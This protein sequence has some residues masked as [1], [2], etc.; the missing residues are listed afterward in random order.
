MLRLVTTGTTKPFYCVAIAAALFLSCHLAGAEIIF[1]DWLSSAGNITNSVPFIDVE[2]DSWQLVPQS[3]SVLVDGQGHASDAAATPASAAIEL[4][5][6][7]PFG[8]M[9]ITATLQLPVGPSNWIGMGFAGGLESLDGVTNQSGPWLKVVNTGTAILYGG[10]ATND[11]TNLPNAYVNTGGSVA[12]LL[13]YNAFN[14]TATAATII[15]GATNVFASA[16]PVNPA[17]ERHLVFECSP[18]TTASTNLWFSAVSVDWF[19]RPPPLLSLPV[20]SNTIITKL[21]GAPSG[22]DDTAEIQNALDFAAT[23]GKPTE[24]QFQNEA[25]YEIDY[26]TNVAFI[27]L[28]L[29]R[30]T[31]VWIN[32]NSASILIE[33]PRIG[34]LHCQSCSNVIIQGLSVDYNPLPFT[35]GM[36]TRNLYTDPTTPGSPKYAIEFRVDAGFPTP[37]NANYV[38]SNAMNSAELWGTIMNTNF[39]GRGADDRYTIY[40]YSNVVATSEPGV[41][42][43]EMPFANQLNTIQSNDFWCMVSRWNGSAVYSVGSCCDVTFL[44]LTNHSGPGAS[45]EGTLSPLVSEVNCHV[46]IGPPPLGATRGRMRTS[47][48]DGGYFGSSRIGPWVENCDFTGL[49]DDVANAYAS[50]FVVTNK[51][52]QPTN[53]FALWMY[54][55]GVKGGPPA[56]A[57]SAYLQ[58]GDQL[59]FFDA[60]NGV[61]FDQ[62]AVTA[63]NLPNVTVDHDITNIV[64]GTYETNTLIFNN[65]LNT[66]AVYLND[67][68]SNSRIHGIYCRANN[69]LI[70]H[71]CVSGMGLSAISGFP[72]LNLS[73]PNSFVP[74]NVV[75]MDNVLSDCSYSY[76]AINNSV[77][78]QEP[79][80][81][82][83][84][85]HQTRYTSDYVSNTFGI[86]G[87]R[88]LN[89]AFLDWRR[90]PLSLHN[91]TDFQVLGNYFGPPITSDGLWPLDDDYIVDLWSCNYTNMVISSNINNTGISNALTVS[92]DFY[93]TV[94]PG[95]FRHLTAPQLTLSVDLTNAVV[96]WSSSSP[97]YILQQ[98]GVLGDPAYPWVDST[99]I[100]FIMGNSNRVSMPIVPRSP[101]LFLRAVPR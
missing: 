85:L 83:V 76:E 36:V 12:F 43:V 29:S 81:A 55:T 97:G 66:S 18:G 47:N 67:N 92:E 6:I 61:I 35:Q 100:P 13:T 3:A 51:L 93:F 16:F 22:G 88:I 31:N 40:N 33:N 21:V 72:A 79:A 39:P 87:I 89:N 10:P 91:V 9:T 59:D 77:P 48:A 34:F 71:N 54:N 32:G 2:G 38:D 78:G 94:V 23:N 73:S 14:R 7:G 17:L 82:L 46:E 52:R 80:F 63:V 50:P 1:Q 65:S 56:A 49:G 57:T 58:V 74:T 30:A 84:E 69:M 99:N 11:S 41:F 24:V 27:P 75:I 70:A 68:F 101:G 28:S 25:S 15:Q 95:A 45:F 42:E 86:S 53:T 96:A 5:P 37:T 62:A 60:L 4:I 44:D 8:S 20:P 64:A 98:T 26:N 90:A 19:P